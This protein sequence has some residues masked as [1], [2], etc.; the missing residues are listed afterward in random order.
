M[1]NKRPK[2]GIVAPN[3]SGKGGTE[4]VLTKVINFDGFKEKVEFELFLSDGTK[5]YSWLNEL[6]IN[7]RNISINNHNGFRKIIK[8]ITFFIRSSDD[9][10]LALGPKTILLAWI[11]R[12]IFFKK[13]KIVSWIHFSLVNGP[14]KHVN[15]IKYADYHFAISTGIVNQLLDMGVN[16]QKIFKIYNPV[17]KVSAVVQVSKDNIRRIVYVGRM[18]YFGQKNL[19]FLIDA[20]SKL[21][22]N[23]Y[24]ELNMYGDGEDVYKLKDYCSKIL[25][26]NIN[27]RWHGWTQNPW[28]KIELADVLVLTSIYEGF[29][30]VLAEA[31]SRG[32]P[33]VSTDAP[34]GPSDI[35]QNGKN[36]FL[37]EIGD[38]DN[39]ASKVNCAVDCF[40]SVDKK[41]I[42][43]SI[44]YLYSESFYPR[45]KGA[46]S[47]ILGN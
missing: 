14:V 28:E 17:E 11:I 8:K 16:R 38:V 34:V 45:F 19:K 20:L 42:K 1:R 29:G 37:V 41:E 9:M 40:H 13:Y 27:V 21:P 46:L 35:V 6:K 39:F 7:K 33:V 10:I 47:Q 31:I 25:T 22:K 12:L 5:D 26:E 44:S 18:T 4:T 30:M 15:L 23:R 43:Q 3:I 32:V 24:Y 2:I 36:G